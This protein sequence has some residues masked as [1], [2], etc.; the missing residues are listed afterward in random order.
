MTLKDLRRKRNEARG[1]MP[2]PKKR[3]YRRDGSWLARKAAGEVC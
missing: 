2:R 3:Q 1:K